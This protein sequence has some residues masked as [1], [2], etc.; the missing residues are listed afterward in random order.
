[1]DQPFIALAAAFASALVVSWLLTAGM[2]RWAPRLGLI[3]HPNERSFHIEQT[4][5]GG[6]IAIFVGVAV[7]L[8][9][10]APGRLLDLGIGLLVL[11]LG[12]AD[13]F[14]QLPWQFRLAAQAVAAAAAFGW[15]PQTGWLPWPLAILWVV[16][17]INAFNMLDNMD[18]LSAGVAA[19]AAVFSALLLL[20]EPDRI[21]FS[22]AATHSATLLYVAL[23]GA[24]L[25]FL[26]FNRPPARIF[27]GDA[28]STFLGFFFGVRS[29]QDGFADA[30]S[31]ATWL[32]PLCILAVPW[33]DLVAVVL[34]RLS[35]RRSPFHADKQHLSHRLVERG[36]AA[37]ATVGLIHVLGFVGGAFALVLASIPEERV[38][39]LA[40]LLAAC[41]ACL[42][43]ADF[44]ARRRRAAKTQAD[45]IGS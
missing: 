19:I 39:P 43:A 17:L 24:V 26:W 38:W 4:P 12:L 42:A 20:I 37:P 31:P 34:L 32:I 27:M 2:L 10:L 35:Q 40:I 45:V 21:G 41:W 14:K 9:M 15:P 30:R 11:L 28:G 18:A 5:K 7:A 1:M 3:D 36:F 29:L 8:A 22:V 25:G 23:L 6:G 44:L 13:D 33:Y 16:G